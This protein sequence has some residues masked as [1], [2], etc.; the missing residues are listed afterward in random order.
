MPL[1]C[2]EGNYQTATMME[3]DTAFK[4]MGRQTR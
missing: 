1:M 3:L 2:L 4:I